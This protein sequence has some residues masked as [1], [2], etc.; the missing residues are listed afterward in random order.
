MH[1]NAQ[2][3]IVTDLDTVRAL[4]DVADRPCCRRYNIDF[5][6]FWNV[7]RTHSRCLAA[8]GTTRERCTDIAPE[9]TLLLLEIGAGNSSW[10]GLLARKG[11]A[12][13]STDI[14][15]GVR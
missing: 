8:V 9:Q 7:L 3:S 11:I 2:Y 5:G 12:V 14:D 6:I 1:V 13:V 10:A 4:F 15:P